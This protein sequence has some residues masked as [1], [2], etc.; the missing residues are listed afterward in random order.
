MFVVRLI[1]FLLGASQ[2]SVTPAQPPRGQVCEWQWRRHH[3]AGVGVPFS[4]EKRDPP[5]SLPLSQT[6]LVSESPLAL[7]L[8]FVQRLGYL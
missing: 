1:L 2:T 3:L 6:I 8:P 4:L 5:E 7:L